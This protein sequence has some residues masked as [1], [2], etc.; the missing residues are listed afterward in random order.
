MA[1]K[2]E[3]TNTADST[4]DNATVQLQRE[5]NNIT[6][7]DV[8]EALGVSKTTVSRAI[9]GKGRIG[10][11]TTKRVLDYIKENHYRPNVVAKGLAKSKTYNIG[12]VMPGD[13][14]VSDLPF[15]QRCMMGISE[16]AASG[17][18]DIL[19]SMVFDRDISQLKSIVK[20]RKVDGIILGR[21]LVEDEGIKFLKKSDM[22][23]VV[24]GS[25]VDDGVIQIDNDHVKACKELTAIVIMKGVRRLALIGGS[26]NHV[27]N[28]TRRE[29][30]EMGLMEQGVPVNQDLIYMDCETDSAVER[31]V[32]NCLRNRAECIITTD[33]R[34]CHSVLEKL[35][36]DGVRIPDQLKVASF[37]SSIMLENNQPAITSLHYDPKELGIVACKTLFDYLAGK[38][39]QKKVLLGYE[40]VL[41]GSTQ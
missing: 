22:P 13:S 7:G 19:I 28:L 31:A 12:W 8:A 20:N 41:K 9:S 40:V 29:G 39:V 25:S 35:G 27:V 14:N 32:D 4:I 3:D 15:F 23:F 37:Y 24:I 2:E 21:T 30:F 1:L 38:E 17:D 33:D 26:T 5:R 18:Y 6:I 34:I 36:R 16:V 10:A 11:E